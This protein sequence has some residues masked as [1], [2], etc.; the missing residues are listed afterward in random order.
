MRLTTVPLQILQLIDVTAA[1][2]LRMFSVVFFSR[3]VGFLRDLVGLLLGGLRDF[4]QGAVRV[5][6][7]P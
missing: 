4:H 5:S 2:G 6:E 3:K 7:G 1:A